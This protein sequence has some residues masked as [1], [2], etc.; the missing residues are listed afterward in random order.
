MKKRLSR[1]MAAVGIS[2]LLAAAGS[3]VVLDAPSAGAAT[4][5]PCDIYTS[6]GTPCVAAHSTTRAL[7]GAYNG[8]LYQVRRSSDNTTRDIGVLSAGG[9]ANAATQDSF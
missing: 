6:S 9:V 7:Y 2:L 3:Y 4:T 8:P 1:L 5:G